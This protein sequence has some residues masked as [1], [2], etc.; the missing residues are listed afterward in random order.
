MGVYGFLAPGPS[1]AGLS[2]F[3]LPLVLLSPVDDS[4]GFMFSSW[5][6]PRST[7]TLPHQGVMMFPT[8][9]PF[10]VPR[11]GITPPPPPPP[12][13]ANNVLYGSGL[14]FLFP[15]RS[16]LPYNLVSHFA[17][18]WL[19]PHDPF[20]RC[21]IPTQNHHDAFSVLMATSIVPEL[22][23][24]YIPLGLVSLWKQPPARYI[25]PQTS[26]VIVTVATTPLPA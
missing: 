24:L 16:S 25:R 11:R 2:P 3:L 4:R 15:V 7:P 26:Q 10:G 14:Q 13:L 18:D 21:S 20:H 5:G 1:W 23:Y 9:P 17:S 8:P 19:R 12:F 6:M 22:I